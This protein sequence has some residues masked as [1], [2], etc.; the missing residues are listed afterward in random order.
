MEIKTV[1]YT[2]SVSVQGRF[3]VTV[4]M[5]ED[6]PAKEAAKIAA[7]QANDAVSDADFGS[8]EDIDWHTGHVETEKGEYIYLDD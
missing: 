4:D 3:Y 5:P 2:V 7:K 8:L 6:M 1:P